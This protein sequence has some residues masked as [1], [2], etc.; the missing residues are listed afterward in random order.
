MK[1]ALILVVV[2]MLVRIDIVWDLVAKLHSKIPTKK[3]NIEETDITPMGE[4]VSY[5]DDKSLKQSPKVRLIG[6]MDIFSQRPDLDMKTSILS[7]FKKNASAFTDIL[8]KELEG[9][10]FRWRGLI[11][12]GN[13]VVID[14]LVEL[15]PELQ[16]A[17][18]LM[19]RKFFSLVLD[20]DAVLFLK[21][22]AKTK[23]LSCLGAMYFAD[24]LTPEEQFGEY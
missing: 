5:G 24:E 18:Q 9:A 8:D 14:L 16:G 13:P 10:I 17:N 20:Q 3:E 6:L 22:Y 4:S 21:G 2:V 11:Q 12:Q 1:Y 23:D 19:A 15:I 7:E